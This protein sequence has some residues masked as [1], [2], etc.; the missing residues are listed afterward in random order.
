[1]WLLVDHASHDS[2]KQ[3]SRWVCIGHG[4]RAFECGHSLQLTTKL[5]ACERQHLT[6]MPQW[7]SA[8]PTHLSKPCAGHRPST[9][10][11]YCCTGNRQS[12]F[13]WSFERLQRPA[14]QLEWQ[15][16]LKRSRVFGQ[17]VLHACRT[18]GGWGCG[19]FVGEDKKLMNNRRQCYNIFIFPL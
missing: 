9:W 18:G 2:G 1:M 4:R 14:N 8:L 3:S 17:R 7:F 19:F 15:Q 11:V 16:H 10:K 12:I 13:L 6:C 5:T